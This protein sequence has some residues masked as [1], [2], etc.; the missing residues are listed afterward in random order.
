MKPNILPIAIVLSTIASISPSR[1]ACGESD[2]QVLNSLLFV[3]NTETICK[4]EANQNHQMCTLDA[5]KQYAD[6]I[7]KCKQ[8]FP[9]NNDS[10]EQLMS[11]IHQHSLQEC[12]S[13]KV[14]VQKQCSRK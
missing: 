6:N 10:C 13:K 14:E 12:D 8:D 3:T 11:H 5:K 9:A 4:N 1:L 2:Q 7:S